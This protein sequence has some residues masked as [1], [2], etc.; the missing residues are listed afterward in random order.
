ML[1]ICPVVQFQGKTWQAMLGAV[2]EVFEQ[3]YPQVGPQQMG[4]NNAH[5]DT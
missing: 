1:A 4:V 5:T 3:S 2:F